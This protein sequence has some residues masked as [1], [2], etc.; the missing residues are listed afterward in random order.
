MAE[1]TEISN[2]GS[3][4]KSEKGETSKRGQS[5]QEPEPAPE[6]DDKKKK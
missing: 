2:M 3:F 4:G 6:K 1:Q 5:A